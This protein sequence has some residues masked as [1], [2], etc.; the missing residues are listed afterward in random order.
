MKQV[1]LALRRHPVQQALVLEDFQNKTVVVVRKILSQNCY[2]VSGRGM[3]HLKMTQN[4]EITNRDAVHLP[5]TTGC[6]EFE[7]SLLTPTGAH[8]ELSMFRTFSI[9]GTYRIGVSFHRVMMSACCQLIVRVKG[10]EER[11]S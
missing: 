2:V 4:G 5:A 1:E 6:A 11:R 8:W 10:K 9:V 7:P 3:T